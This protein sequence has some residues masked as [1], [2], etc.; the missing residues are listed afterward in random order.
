MWYISNTYR[1]QSTAM[2]SE[3][4]SVGRPTD[5]S[6]ITIVTSPAWGIPAA[7]ILAAVAVMLMGKRWC[8]ERNWIVFHLHYVKKNVLSLTA[9]L[10]C[11]LLHWRGS[12]KFSPFLG[13]KQHP[14]SIPQANKL[15]DW[16]LENHLLS[17]KLWFWGFAWLKLS[18]KPQW[19][20]CNSNILMFVPKLWAGKIPRIKYETLNKFHTWWWESVRSSGHSRWPGRW[21]WQPGLHT[22]L[23]HP[24]LLSRRQGARSESHACPLCCFPP[25]I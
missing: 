22:E 4:S 2:M 14:S 24:C 23:C 3:M 25:G 1:N 13:L 16:W 9:G 21:R 7:P 15:T 6:T 12:L 18:S 11:L 20:T 19:K 5:V 17:W 10:F 8:K